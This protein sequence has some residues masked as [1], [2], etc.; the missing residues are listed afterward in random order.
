[1][2]HRVFE[3]VLYTGLHVCCPIR[4]H[5]HVRM[6]ITQLSGTRCVLGVHDCIVVCHCYDMQQRLPE[7]NVSLVGSNQARVT[8]NNSSSV[9]Q[10]TPT[11]RPRGVVITPL[12][13]R[14]AAFS[15][16]SPLKVYQRVR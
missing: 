11:S 12:N 13:T 4:S 8:G 1:M 10:A 6:R 14:Y 7:C 15:K 3:S 9:V 5:A 16:V 2:Y